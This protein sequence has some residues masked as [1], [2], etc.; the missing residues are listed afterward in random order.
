[1]VEDYTYAGLGFI[2]MYRLSGDF[3]HL[4]FARDLCEV[5]VREF[6]DPEN[7][8]FFETTASGEK[9]LVRQKSLF[10]EATPSG[11]GSGAQLTWVLSRYF[12][13]E[14]WSGIAIDVVSLSNQYMTQAPNG[15]G[16]LWQ[17]AELLLAPRQELVI[18]GEPAAREPLE[19]AA[20]KQ[21]LPWLAL[22]PGN[23][24]RIPLLE[25]R[26]D[27]ADALAYFCENM[28]CQLPVSDPQILTE[29]LKGAVVR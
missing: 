17:T 9:L 18:T 10:D 21:F 2:E 27:G 25:G 26:T 23:E 1:M 19:R 24:P 6:H 28:T 11:N 4:E 22:A 20:A 14:E 16:S 13:R 7:G 15:M 5:L 29:Q 3:T 12:E 8:G